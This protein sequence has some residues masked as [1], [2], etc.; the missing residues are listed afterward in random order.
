V[1]TVPIAYVW[2]DDEYAI[3][4]TI[5]DI[6]RRLGD[7]AGTP[8]ERW[9]IRFEKNRAA[10]QF[11]E[12][13]ERL[14]TGVMFGG[15]TLAVAFNLGLAVTS[16]ATRER[17]VA[18]LKDLP[19]GNALVAVDVVETGKVKRAGGATVLPQKAMAEALAGLGAAL[20]LCE[21]PKAGRL[22]DWISV[23][24]HDRG[25]ALGPGAAKELAERIGGFVSQ[26]D[27]ERRYQT[28]TASM[29][30]DK[31]ALYREGTTITVDDVRALVA[32]AVPG[33]I[34]AFSDAVAER[35]TGPALA[36]LEILIGTTTDPAVK[37]PTSVPE[38]VLI[39][40]LHRRIRELIEMGDRLASGE[41]LP[42][43]AKE[44]RINSEFRARNLAS[45]A[46][47]WTIPELHAALDGLLELDALIK[48]AP[49]TF[50][51][52]AQRRLAFTLWVIDHVGG[53]E[54]RSA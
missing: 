7:E 39:T 23:Q 3:E 29:E 41:R 14:G 34:W 12:L 35:K 5:A 51:D 8:L 27:A 43:A 31:L 36:Y 30:L 53:R 54:R 52:A 26:A 44:M 9:D 22:A 6:A 24:A 40:V 33:S 4:R 49:G 50:A 18:T 28:R 10:V 15:G 20:V 45:Q 47:H 19:P 17:L 2:G 11:E 16:K 1:T 25:L 21:S 13:G 46:R 42:A 48:G 37:A 38:P 32:E